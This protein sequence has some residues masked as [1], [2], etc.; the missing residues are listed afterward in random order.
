MSLEDLGIEHKK[1]EKTLFASIPCNIKERKEL[2]A[3]LDT[4]TQKIPR[5]YITGPAFY[6]RQFV[7]SFKEGLDIEMGFPVSKPVQVDGI[8]TR[9][10]PGMEVLS[11]VHKGPVE[12]RTETYGKLYG[13][14]SEHGLISDEFSIEVFIDA[15]KVDGNEF[16]LYFILHNW[17]RLFS[18]NLN[19]VLG[20]KARKEVMQGIEKLTFESTIAE[21]FQWTRGA[22]ERLDN[23][24]DEDQK[25]DILSS[26]AH[27]FPS[28]PIEKARTVYE[29]VKKQTGDS[30]KAVDA[31]IEHMDEDNAFVRPQREGR[32]IYDTKNPAYP[33][34]YEK[35]TTDIER[36]KAACFCPTVRHHFDEGMSDTYCYCGS[37]WCRRQWELITGKPV[38]IDVVQSVL[39]GDS[40]CQ[41]AIHLPDDL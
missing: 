12:K 14:I 22:V 21:R 30:L 23:L 3:V 36:R 2:H 7:T 32:I 39:K 24:A 34:D 8:R 5:E 27:V 26:C 28:A 6:I 41:F 33:Q 37:G 17:N 31:V 11:I 20:E 38:R 29:T 40:V 1:L 19:R 18:E 4:L 15:N 25:Y 16:E 35:A 13:F 9:T 10:L